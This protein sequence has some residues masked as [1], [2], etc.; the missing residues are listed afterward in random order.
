MRKAKLVWASALP[1]LLLGMVYNVALGQE[2][3]T[4]R[5]TNNIRWETYTDPRYGFSIEYPSTWYVRPRDDSRGAGATLSFRNF[6]SQTVQGE[7]SCS[8]NA[9]HQQSLT[10]EIGVYFV[11][12]TSDVSLESV[13]KVKSDFRPK[14]GL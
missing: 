14:K 12:W 5:V 9:S 4:H 11:E 8:A 3:P 13:V 6:D 10:V 1:V 7:Q 2:I